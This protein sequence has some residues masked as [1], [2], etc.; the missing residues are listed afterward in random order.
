[1]D[2]GFHN[3]IQHGRPRHP[4]TNE[5]TPVGRGQPQVPSIPAVWLR[6]REKKKNSMLPSQRSSFCCLK[7]A[8][9]F[10]RTLL[11]CSYLFFP[12]ITSRRPDRRGFSVNSDG[13]V[14]A[15]GVDP[16]LEPL[17]RRLRPKGDSPGRILSHIKQS[18]DRT[19]RPRRRVSGLGHLQPVFVPLSAPVLINS[20]E[21]NCAH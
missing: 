15:A 6:N 12:S 14:P 10:C 18:S 17:S 3:L 9:T 2:A 8:A 4:E 13:N 11:V 7:S 21:E 16:T 1:M 19:E 20:G 5:D